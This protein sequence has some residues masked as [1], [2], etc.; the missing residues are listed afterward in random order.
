M[1]SAPE[2]PSRHGT[3]LTAVTTSTGVTEDAIPDADP[4]N[5]AG[6]LA[7]RLQAWKHACGYL[8]EYIG[9][10]EKVHKEQASQYEKVLKTISKPLREG[11]H[12]DQTLGGVSG[13]FDNMRANTQALINTNLETEKNIKGSV[14]PILDRLHKEIKNKAKELAHGAQRGAKEV[15]KARALTQKQ[16]EL[17]GQQTAAFEA[18]GGRLGPGED[19]YVLNRGVIYRLNKQVVEENNH[20]NDLLAVQ[21]NFETFETHVIQVLQQSMEAFTL[22]AGGQAERTS[23]LF[24]DML[25]AVQRIPPD[26]EWKS[27]TQ[28]F[29]DTL[30]DPNEPLR[31]VDAITFPNQDHQSTHAVIEG[32]LERKSRNKLAWGYQ[33]GYYVVT[34]SRFLHE[35]KDSDNVRKEPVP[36][37]SIYLPD[38]VISVPAGDRFTVKGKDRSKSVGSRLAGS[39]E[40]QFKAHGPADAEKWFYI[41]RDVAGSANP[42]SNNVLLANDSGSVP[43]SPIAAS[44]TGTT[45]TAGSAGASPSPVTTSSP[46]AGAA[47]AAI[48]ATTSAATTTAAAAAAPTTAT[49]TATIS[50]TTPAVTHQAQEAGITGSGSGS[51]SG[52][53]ATAVSDKAI[54]A[55]AAAPEK[56]TGA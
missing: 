49:T 34:P 3:G 42:N 4:S 24:G 2:L 36:E 45:G 18:S 14:L 38:A 35:F 39:S 33:T 43:T 52:S 7:E 15:D 50:N 40:L 48:P 28:R 8:E 22:F 56:A 44:P 51:G 53:G 10:V 13:F 20:H 37:L 31:A 54:E 47:A 27:F 30:A 21:A 6:L 29:H 12:F 9:A 5:A 55:G 26:M 19:P 32:T 23:A 41:I 1:A 25:S 17:L 11:Q 16:I 46:P